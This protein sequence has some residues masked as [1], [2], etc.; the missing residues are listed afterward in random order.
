VTTSKLRVLLV[1]YEDFRANSASHVSNLGNQLAQLGCHVT[2]AVPP[3]PVGPQVMSRAD[4]QVISYRDCWNHWH[5]HKFDIVHVW[6]PRERSDTFWQRVP[7]TGTPLV[8]HLEDNEDYLSARA[9]K[10]AV[11]E[12]D[13]VGRD[14]FRRLPRNRYGRLL[15]EPVRWKQFVSSA[16]GVT[17][18][19]ERLAEFVRPSQPHLELWPG[20]DSLGVARPLEPGHQ[21][22]LVYPGNVHRANWEEVRSLY[23]G[24]ALANRNGV[25]AR[26]IRF[27]T[28]FVDPVGPDLD[29][30]RP[31]VV[32]H[33]YV[34][35]RQVARAL[36][37]A[38]ALVQ[39]GRPGPFNDYRIPSKLPEFIASGRPT[40][41]PF[42]NLGIPLRHGHVCTV[43]DQVGA[44]EIAG[45]IEQLHRDGHPGAD[46]Q[47]AFSEQQLSWSVQAAR[48][49]DFYNVILNADRKEST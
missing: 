37:T 3:G 40:M 30:V 17:V 38:A 1:L 35:H 14:R 39:P 29:S 11:E 12:L 46:R 27:G 31:H 22:E 9:L 42:S 41:T 15:A 49:R 43:P 25:P 5:R 32:E 19:T 47:I 28:N 36:A 34:P 13:T 20:Y 16:T 7:R 26:L 4:Y 6:T 33:G 18:I 44:L 24:V 10:C 2:V 48:V 21:I 23:L 8:V 45:F